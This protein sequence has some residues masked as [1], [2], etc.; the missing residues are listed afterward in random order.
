MALQD[1]Y[2]YTPE[3]KTLPNGRI[4]YKSLIPIPIY[5]DPINDTQITATDVVRMDV[6]AFN[7]YGSAHEWW[8]I[9]AANAKADGSLYFRPG[10]TIAIPGK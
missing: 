9:A 1:R 5:I 6:L 2:W 8:R 7:A 4:A 3:T 10:T